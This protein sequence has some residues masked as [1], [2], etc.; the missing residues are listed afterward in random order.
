MWTQ[1]PYSSVAKKFEVYPTCEDWMDY[2]VVEMPLYKFYLSSCRNIWPL[3]TQEES[4]KGIE[5]AEGF[6]AG[7]VKWDSISEY[8]WHVEGAAFCFEDPP[9]QERIDIW[10]KEVE[11][12]SSDLINKIRNEDEEKISTQELLKQAA[13]FADYAMIYPSIQPKGLPCDEFN[14]FLC[15]KLLKQHVNYPVV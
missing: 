13:Y 7:K 9:D 8:N 5:L 3:L 4:R 6:V 15:P 11:C 10:I 12:Q 2:L 1:E 14:R